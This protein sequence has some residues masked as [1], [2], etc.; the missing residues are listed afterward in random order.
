[1]YAGGGFHPLI[2]FGI[3]VVKGSQKPCVAMYAGGGF[4]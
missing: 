4:M 3:A 1:M 2:M